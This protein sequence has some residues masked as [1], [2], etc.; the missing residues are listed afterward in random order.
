MGK[1]MEETN[2]SKETKKS[3][4]KS[5]WIPAFFFFAWGVAILEFTDGGFISGIGWILAS[6]GWWAFSKEKNWV[7]TFIGLYRNHLN[8]C[9]KRD[10]EYK[11][12]IQ[13]YEDKLS[14]EKNTTKLA[15]FDVENM[16]IDDVLK[17][18]RD[19]Q[20]SDTW[21]GAVHDTAKLLCDTIEMLRDK[22]KNEE[23]K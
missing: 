11:A 4:W 6:A 15:A 5:I 10:G 19:F 1:S 16:S 7:D 12:K 3:I 21:R 14:N 8:E 23:D 2:E 13:E 17:I 20:R 22:V 9:E 18:G